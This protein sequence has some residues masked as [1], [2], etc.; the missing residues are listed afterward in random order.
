MRQ[1]LLQKHFIVEK[2]NTTVYGDYVKKTAQLIDRP[3]MVTFRMV[4]SWEPSTMINLYEECIQKWRARN[5]KSP[6]MMWWTERKKM[7]TSK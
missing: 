4:Q 1:E 7:K 6:A 3:Y 2:N 5:Y